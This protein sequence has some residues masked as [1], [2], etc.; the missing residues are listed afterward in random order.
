MEM[1]WGEGVTKNG[2][3]REKEGKEGECDI[4]VKMITFILNMKR[5]TKAKNKLKIICNQFIIMN[6]LKH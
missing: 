1:L 3:I 2:S 5:K 4:E 6:M